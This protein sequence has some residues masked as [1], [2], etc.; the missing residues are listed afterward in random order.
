VKTALGDDA[1]LLDNP[2]QLKAHVADAKAF[3]AALVDDI[4]A[5]ERQLKI[6]G[7]TPEDVTAAKAFLAEFSVERLQTMQK[8][9]EK[10][11]GSTAQIKG[12]NTN[13]GGPGAQEAPADSLI[14]NPAIAA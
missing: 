6:T 8:G 10:R 2:A 1:A 9:Y 3:K 11:M 14:N 12:A 7:D 4:V 5:I 13:A